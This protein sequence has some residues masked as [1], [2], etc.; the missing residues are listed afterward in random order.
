MTF[1]FPTNMDENDSIIITNKDEVQE[2]N[3]RVLRRIT[4][5]IYEAIGSIKL[6]FEDGVETL[7]FGTNTKQEIDCS[8]EVPKGEHIVG[9]KIRHK[10][11]T[12]S[13]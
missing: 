13:I 2:F 8:L 7:Q 10:S 6:H 11:S 4:C 5:G 12:A 9:I 1:A 3:R